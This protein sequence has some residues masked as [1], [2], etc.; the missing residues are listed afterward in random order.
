MGK[1]RAGTPQCSVL[2]YVSLGTDPP[3]PPSK[4]EP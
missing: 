3:S 4:P 1:H 2:A